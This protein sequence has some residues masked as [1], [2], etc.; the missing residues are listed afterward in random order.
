MHLYTLVLIRQKT[1]ILMINRTH[2][3]WLGSW[4][5]LGG[6]RLE[7]ETPD[8][9]IRREI[10]EETGL[11]LDQMDIVFKGTLTWNSFSANGRG[12]Y[13]YLA[14]LSS[15]VTLITPIMTREG[16][17]DWKEISW[18]L[19]P[20]NTGVA[21]NI[22]HFLVNLLDDPGLWTYHCIF[23]GNTLVSVTKERCETDAV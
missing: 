17:L 22:P 11:A 23:A 18:L 4:N 12:L 20:R 19:D 8:A 9:C 3:P 15:D 1:K 7:G 6:K 13:L 21:A 16:I 10:I 5:G 2:A 14:D